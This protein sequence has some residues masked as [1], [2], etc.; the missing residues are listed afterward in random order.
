MQGMTPQGG[1]SSGCDGGVAV[2]AQGPP[3]VPRPSVCPPWLKG[4]WGFTCV[5][6][7]TGLT[8]PSVDN[9]AAIQVLAFGGAE[10]FVG[11]SS[12]LRSSN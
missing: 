8:A 11:R 6:L 2:D 7:M 3:S 12:C 5:G 10:I 1:S 9:R 4:G